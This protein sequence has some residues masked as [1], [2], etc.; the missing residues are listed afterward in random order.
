[1]QHTGTTARTAATQTQKH[2]P[3]VSIA[4]GVAS[5]PGA[6]QTC[7]GVCRYAV[8]EH[9]QMHCVSEYVNCACWSKQLAGA[10]TKGWK[11]F[12]QMQCNAKCAFKN[13][14]S[15]E[16]CSPRQRIYKEA[17]SPALLTTGLI[18][19]RLECSVFHAMSV[20][21]IGG[22]TCAK[23][24]GGHNTQEVCTSPCPSKRRCPMQAAEA[25]LHLAPFNQIPLAGSLSQ[26]LAKLNSMKSSPRGQARRSRPLGGTVIN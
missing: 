22:T 13:K 24:G 16:R 1:M 10:A 6:S 3:H 23:P 17:A 26:R 25:G 18:T 4:F 2:T 9:H 7:S 8:W 14:H 19:E 20:S 15:S 12:Q 11:R 21:K 5:N